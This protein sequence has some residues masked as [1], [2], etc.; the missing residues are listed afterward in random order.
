M[1]RMRQIGRIGTG[2]FGLI[3]PYSGKRQF[4]VF[5]TSV[6]QGMNSVAEYKDGIGKYAQRFYKDLSGNKYVNCFLFIH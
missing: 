3:R 5:E 6:R 4:R 2:L 1:R